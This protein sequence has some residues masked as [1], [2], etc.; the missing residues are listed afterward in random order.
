MKAIK[1]VL[2][3]HRDRLLTLPGVFGVAVASGAE[4][5]CI[6]LHAQKATEALKQ[7]APTEIEGYSVRIKEMGQAELF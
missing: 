2:E 7:A 5:P 3:A 4:G 6:E 1:A